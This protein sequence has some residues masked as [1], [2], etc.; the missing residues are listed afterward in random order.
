MVSLTH[1]VWLLHCKGT[2]L[3]VDIVE[4]KLPVDTFQTRHLG[5]HYLPTN[6]TR[7]QKTGKGAQLS[8][9]HLCTFVTKF[10]VR[11]TGFKNQICER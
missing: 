10:G 3:R 5:W 1:V 7:Q 8:S 2:L 11:N 9:G 4:L 6:I